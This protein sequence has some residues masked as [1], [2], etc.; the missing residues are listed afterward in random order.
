[1]ANVIYDILPESPINPFV[2]LGFGINRLN[3]DVAGQFAT[4]PGAITTAN[5][6]IQNLTIDNDSDGVVAYQALAGLAWQATDRLD[7]DLTYRYLAGADAKF[8]SRGSNALQPGEA[9]SFRTRLASPPPDAHDIV[10]RFVNRRDIL[11]GD[12]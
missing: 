11:A 8:G 5:P 2:G 9:E 4:V 12:R 7:V 1:M 10:L 3:F 6:A